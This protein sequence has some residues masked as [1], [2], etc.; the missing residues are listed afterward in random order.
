MFRPA[1][2][3]APSLLAMSLLTATP[4]RA[5][6]ERY[7]ADVFLYTGRN[8]EVQLMDG[9]PPTVTVFAIIDLPTALYVIFSNDR[10]YNTPLG[11]FQ[12]NKEFT[13]LNTQSNGLYDVRCVND[14]PYTKNDVSTLKFDGTR[15]RQ[16]F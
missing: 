13:L 2:L 10:S 4:A 7:D 14:T 5:Q 12:C 1:R 8:F 11:T 6:F 15:Y 16:I 3:F 9:H